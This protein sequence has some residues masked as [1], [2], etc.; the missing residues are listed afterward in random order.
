MHTYPLF[1][2]ANVPAYL[3]IIAAW[4]A[5]SILN[6]ILLS[7]VAKTL[8][9]TLLLA[10]S[11][12]AVMS[13]MAIMFVASILNLRKL[14]PGFERLS[15]GQDPHIPPVWCPVLTAATNSALSLYRKMHDPP[16]PERLKEGIHPSRPGR[17][18]KQS[19]L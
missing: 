18:D 11:G 19:K 14:E 13:G 1:H 4:S 9:W 5:L 8:P 15:Q 7:M 16:Q 3:T 12:A 17:T 2:K 6:A 10:S